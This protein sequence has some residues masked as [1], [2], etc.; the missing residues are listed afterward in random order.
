MSTILVV[1]LNPTFQQSFF[2][3]SFQKNDVNR[4]YAHNEQIAGKGFNLVRILRLLGHRCIYLSHLGKSRFEEV[5]KEC[6]ELGIEMAYALSDSPM[7]TCVTLLESDTCQT[8]EL[9]CNAEP[10]CPPE[11]EDRIRELYDSITRRSDVGFVIISGTQAP[12]YSPALFPDMVRTASERNLKTVLDICDA[13]LLGS[14]AYHPYI[15]KP[16]RKEFER[17]FQ[18]PGAE[19][20]LFEKTVCEASRKY[21]TTFVITCGERGAYVCGPGDYEKGV[22]LPVAEYVEKPVNATGC[23]DV[24]TAGLTASLNDGHPLSAAI[25]FGSQCAARRV[26]R[27]DVGL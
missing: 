3:K 22:W 10:I 8:T 1:N 26:R 15:V 4:A 9:T 19:D 2:Y 6:E 14:L 13:N 20:R 5:R 12:G 21:G 27:M 16:N 11:I 24:F 23:G 25:L 18:I 7:R 17:T